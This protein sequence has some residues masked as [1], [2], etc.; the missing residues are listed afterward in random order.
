LLAVP[1]SGFGQRGVLTNNQGRGSATATP[2]P[3]PSPA[4]AQNPAARGQGQP[5]PR[6]TPS[7]EQFFDAGWWNDEAVKKEIKLTEAQAKRITQIYDRRVRLMTPTY[8][9]LLKER[10]T[11]ER[12]TR[13]RTVDEATFAAQV[14]KTQYL[15]SKLSESRTVM[16]YTIY[17]VL[18]PKQ[19][20]QLRAIRDR[21]RPGRGGGAPAR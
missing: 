10:A 16:L 2:T 7:A 6:P 9:D 18:D 19:Y 17:M 8:E 14:G 4:K 20:E 21:M 1:V 15:Q 12:I 11:L 3:T 13:E 5:S